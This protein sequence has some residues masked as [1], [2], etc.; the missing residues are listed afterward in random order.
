[1][2]IQDDR[3]AHVFSC[4]FQAGINGILFLPGFTPGDKRGS[5]DEVAVSEICHDKN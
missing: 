1:M 2:R 4:I 3:Y 5:N